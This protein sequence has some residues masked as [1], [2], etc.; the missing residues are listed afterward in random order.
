MSEFGLD[1]QRVEE[2]I[3]DEKLEAAGDDQVVLGVLDGTTPPAEWIELVGGGHTLILAVEGPLEELAREFAPQID[4]QGGDVVHFRSFLIV[5]PPG[6]TVD[7]SR[8]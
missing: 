1:L 6:Q 4:E 5:T 3:D 7:K 8:L 2:M